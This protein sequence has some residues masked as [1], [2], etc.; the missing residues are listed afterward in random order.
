L[1]CPKLKKL[2][3]RIR[4]SVKKCDRELLVMLFERGLLKGNKLM[5]SETVDAHL[6][7]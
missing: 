1:I 3:R 2:E 7:L 4:T 6:I 5:G